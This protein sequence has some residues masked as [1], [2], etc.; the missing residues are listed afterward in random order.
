M[1]R[2]A[3][4]AGALNVQ[5][6]LP[7]PMA[8]SAGGHGSGSKIF[9]KV[10]RNPGGVVG[11]IQYHCLQK[12]ETVSF[13]FGEGHADTVPVTPKYLTREHQ[14][15]AGMTSGFMQLQTAFFAN[16]DID[17]TLDEHPPQAQI[18]GRVLAQGVSFAKKF[19][20]AGKKN[21]CMSSFF[22]TECNGTSG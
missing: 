15:Q 21:P 12:H 7:F 11:G 18:F 3:L 8:S 2:L 9:E 22:R 17:V 20:A 4:Q 6:I 1:E 13:H 16:R 5:K 14:D 19:D 10:H